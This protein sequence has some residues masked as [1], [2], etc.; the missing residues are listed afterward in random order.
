M[1]T[2]IAFAG[3]IRS[4]KD[5]AADYIAS[6]Y[7][8]AGYAPQKI[9]FADAIGGVIETYF[10]GAFD[11]GK[12]REHYQLIG[13]W[14]RQLDPDVWVN[15]LFK[16]VNSRI[17]LFEQYGT[18]EA[19]IIVNDLRQKNELDRLHEEG[20]VTVKIIAAEWTRVKRIEEKG[21]VYSQE[22]LDHPT[23]VSVDGLQTTYT[24]YNDGSYEELTR[25][26]DRLFDMLR[27]ND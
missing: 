20:F 19:A 27:G 2:K 14:F 8:K 15:Q 7:E 9:G 25:K 5:T 26:L 17:D 24:I 11:K 23:E 18:E 4:G 22:A 6:L 12:P 3:R 13:Q 16:R 21:D 10:P 1:R